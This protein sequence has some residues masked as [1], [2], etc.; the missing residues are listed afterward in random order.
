MLPYAPDMAGTTENTSL[1]DYFQGNCNIPQ[2]CT[3]QP[4]ARPSLTKQAE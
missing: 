4:A 2:V 1:T 3:S